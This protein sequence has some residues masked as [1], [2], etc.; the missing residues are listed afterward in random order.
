MIPALLY[1]ELCTL[2]AFYPSI[3]K[4]ILFG[5][6]ARGDFADRSDIDLMIKAPPYPRKIG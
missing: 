3:E 5:S 4:V 2:F 6:R 1:E